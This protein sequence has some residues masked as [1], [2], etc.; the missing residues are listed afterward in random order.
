VCQILS[1]VRR[2]ELFFVSYEF[3]EAAIP[4]ND[5]VD[6]DKLT[7]NILSVAFRCSENQYNRNYFYQLRKKYLMIEILS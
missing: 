2:G 1:S 5:Q 7:G 6:D 3:C 4:F